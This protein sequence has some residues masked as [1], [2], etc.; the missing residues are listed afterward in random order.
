MNNSDLN[1]AH[2]AENSSLQ[3]NLA[4]RILGSLSIVPESSIL[5]VG[6]GDGKITAELARRA[7]AGSVTGVD[8]SPS[9]IEFACEHFSKDKFPNLHFELSPIEHATFDHPFNIITSFSCFHWL[10]NPRE[11]LQKLA[12]YLQEDGQLLILTYPKESPYYRYLEK[13]LEKYPEYKHLSANHTMLSAQEY[14]DFFLENHFTILDFEEKTIVASY[15]SKEEI[16][17]SSYSLT[18]RFHQRCDRS[19]F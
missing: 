9:M 13:A 11:V 15:A 2:Y 8:A 18:R 12:S 7:I 5:D 14:K 4:T 10:K 6:C 17:N 19:Y 3:S 16:F 1:A